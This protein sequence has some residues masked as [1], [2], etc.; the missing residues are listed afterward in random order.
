MAAKEVAA[1]Q[2]AHYGVE[3]VRVGLEQSNQVGLNLH[4]LTQSLENFHPLILVA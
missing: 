1:C 4:P 3:R 2:R